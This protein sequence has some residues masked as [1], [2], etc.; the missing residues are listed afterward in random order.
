M[1]DEPIEV[2]YT[3]WDGSGQVKTTKVCKLEKVQYI[4]LSVQVRKGLTIAQF[5]DRVKQDWKELKGVGV[6]NLMFVK[7]NLIVPHVIIHLLLS[8]LIAFAAL[9]LL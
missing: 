9:Q 8:S 6:D 4:S 3:Y 7:D 2:A 5:M 1:K